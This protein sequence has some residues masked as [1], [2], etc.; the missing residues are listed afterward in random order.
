MAWD[1]TLYQYYLKVY[2]V[3]E[4]PGATLSFETFPFSN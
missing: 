4:G 2:V 1:D 3:D